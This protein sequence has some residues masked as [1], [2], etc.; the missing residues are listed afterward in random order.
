MRDTQLRCLFRGPWSSPRPLRLTSS[1][2]SDEVVTHFVPSFPPLRGR[3][4][5]ARQAVSYYDMARDAGYRGEEA[6]QY[7]EY[8]EQQERAEQERAEHERRQVEP[9]GSPPKLENP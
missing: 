3:I 5:K 4:E 2:P 7:A 1:G 8:I 6:R 9:P